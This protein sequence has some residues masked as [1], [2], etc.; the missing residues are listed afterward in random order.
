MSGVNVWKGDSPQR[1]KG[2]KGYAEVVTVYSLRP[3]CALCASA[4]SP[5]LKASV[6]SP[7]VVGPRSA[8]ISRCPSYLT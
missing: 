6:V 7:S 4:V 5:I 2:R 1:R 3:L 8:R